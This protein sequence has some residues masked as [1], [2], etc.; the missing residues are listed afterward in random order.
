M[1]KHAEPIRNYGRFHTVYNESYMRSSLFLLPEEPSIKTFAFYFLYTTPCVYGL[2]GVFFRYVLQRINSENLYH[3]NEFPFFFFFS[4][5][6]CVISLTILLL[7]GE[8]A[9][10]RRLCIV[11]GLYNFIV[12]TEVYRMTV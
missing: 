4:Y 10:F 8:A 6:L 1:K 11:Y 3:K 9:F 12:F 5:A 2:S 7:K